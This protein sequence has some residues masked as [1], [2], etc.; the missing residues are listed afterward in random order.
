MVEQHPDAIYHK[1]V[2][3]YSVLHQVCEPLGAKENEN[4]FVPFTCTPNMAKIARC[5]ILEHSD[6]VRQRI[7]RCGHLPI[8]LLATRLNHP[9]LQEMVILLLKADPE[10]IE[11]KEGK[12]RPAVPFIQEVY[13]L[14][15]SEV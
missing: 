2:R 12:C 1:S 5:L 6:L 14:L 3:D 4:Q 11:L 10:C 7:H 13:P 8:H 15:M 9:L